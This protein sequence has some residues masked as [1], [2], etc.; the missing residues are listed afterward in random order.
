MAVPEKVENPKSAGY[1]LPVRKLRVLLTAAH[2]SRV[3]GA[4]PKISDIFRDVMVHPVTL[5]LCVY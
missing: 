2:R 1:Y 4:H 5:D 3:I